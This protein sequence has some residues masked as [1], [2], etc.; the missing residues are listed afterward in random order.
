MTTPRDMYETLVRPKAGAFHRKRKGPKIGTERA[1]DALTLTCPIRGVLKTGAKSKDGLKPSEEYFRVEAIKYLLKMGYQRENVKVEAVVKRF[2]NTGR[3]SLRADFAILDTPVASIAPGDVDAL[4]DHAVVLCEVKRDNAKNEYVKETQVKPLLDFAKLKTCIAVYWDNVDQRVFWNEW[5]GDRKEIKE[6]PLALLPKC[7]RSIKVKPLCF[8]DL[9]AT[10]NL[11]EMFDRIENILHAASIDLDQRFSVILQ[12]LLAKLYDEHGHQG[13]PKD[14]LD[15]QDYSVLGSDG[16]AALSAFNGVLSRAVA[17]YQRHL[18]RPIEKALPSRLTGEN[19]LD[20]CKTLAPIRLIA[21]KREVIQSFYMKFAKG[22]YKWDLAQFFTPPT[23]TDFIVDVLNPQFGEHMKDPACGSADFLTAAFHKRRDKEPQYADCIWGSDNSQNAV[24]V[25][26]LN[27]L[28]NG[29]GKSNIKEIDSLEHVG[30][31]KNGYEIMVC[32]PPFGVRIVEKRQKVLDSFDLGHEWDWNEEERRFQRLKK[33]LQAQET[34][35]LFAEVCVIQAKS[36]RGRV[37]IIVPNGYL[38][39]RSKKYRV[40]REWLLCHTRI[41]AICS[42]PR[43]TFKTSGADVSASVVYLEK[44]TTPLKR[45]TDDKDYHFAV[46]MIENVGWNLGD[47]KAAPRY[48]RNQDDGSYIVGED[49]E[50]LLDA[51]FESALADLRRSMA[52]EDFP[53]MVAGQETQ[54]DKL[55]G[56]SVAI[57]E[58]LKDED[59]TLDPKRYCRKVVAL[60]KSIKAKQH[61]KLAEAIDFI[62]ERNTANGLKVKKKNSAVYQYAEIQ[63]IGFGDFRTTECRGWELPDR[64]KHFAEAGDLYVGSIWGS[65]SKWCLIPNNAGEL[66]V[67]NGCHRMRIKPEMT[68]RLVDVVAFLCSEAYAVQMRAFARGS[69]GLAEITQEDAGQV[70]VP[71]LSAVERTALEPYVNDLLSGTPGLHSKVVHMLTKK[72]M[73]YPK[74]A[75]RPSHVVLV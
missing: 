18:P 58:I 74:V 11:I 2:G 34:G 73:P 70:L 49:G 26:V 22:L 1:M 10:D 51:D 6:G 42:F 53:W 17:Y 64:A 41:A 50:R 43:F 54:G 61:F 23:V 35:L 57:K 44:R 31:E 21:S 63:D 32:N 12:F 33:P 55:S 24:Q 69:D 40:F 28:L 59:Y 9:K 45:P 52:A 29:D 72:Q 3:N 30:K 19:L 60:R 37:G 27:M 7:G 20:V 66:V 39:N 71:E 8:E 25:A 4:L 62:Q 65:V 38:G 5:K 56:W 36:E 15:I 48:Q 16:R 46:Q 47:K 13:R 67:T 75:K 14:E 68:K